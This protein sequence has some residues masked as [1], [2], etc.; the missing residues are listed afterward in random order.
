MKIADFMKF[1]K[2]TYR[3]EAGQT[4]FKKIGFN[5]VDAFDDDVEPNIE[6]FVLHQDR[7]FNVA[8]YEIFMR[9]GVSWEVVELFDERDT[10]AT[11]ASRRLANECLVR[12]VSHVL[13]QVFDLIR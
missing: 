12:E 10:F 11:S 9:V 3:A 2:V 6:L 5:W 13:L 4:I 7:I 8:L 1:F